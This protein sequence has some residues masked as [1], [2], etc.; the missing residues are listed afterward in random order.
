M[1]EFKPIGLYRCP[2]TYRY[3]APRQG[4]FSGNEGFVELNGNAGFEDALRDLT[5]FS[6][7]WILFEFHLNETWRPMV[8]PPV[9]PGG[10]RI[11]VFATRSPH[12]PNRLGMSCVKLL[13]VE[14]LRIFVGESDLLDRTPVLDIKPYIP[15]ADAFPDARTGWLEETRPDLW[16]V[17][18]EEEARQQIDLIRSL[19]G[20]DLENFCRIQLSLDP[21]LSDRKRITEE[22]TGEYAIGCRTWQAVFSVSER[23]KSVRV[24]RIR[25]HYTEEELAPGAD[26]KY[27]DKDQHRVFRTRFP[28]RS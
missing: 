24:L 14:G 5:G 10:R 22:D 1:A 19:S 8:R 13:G 4:V 27:G 7:I 12:R 17:T 3:E 9:S 23:E 21:L 11:G 18:F 2:Q 16:Q 6:R 25:S 15:K 20:L 26:D 28:V